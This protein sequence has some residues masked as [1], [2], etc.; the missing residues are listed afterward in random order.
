M[1]VSDRLQENYAHYYE[2]SDSQWRW[3]TSQDKAANVMSLCRDIP[4]STICDI[5]AGE[6]SLLQRLGDAAFGDKHFALEIS[7]TGIEAIRQRSIGTLVECR[8]FDG[9]T[10]PYPD[11]FFDL[12]ILS[13]VVEHVEHPRRLLNEAGRIANYILVEVPLED[14]IRLPADYRFDAVGHINYYSPKTVRHLVQTCGFE[15]VKQIITNRSHS[16]YTFRSGARGYIPYVAKETLLRLAP[17]FATLLF[18]YHSA[19]L[20]RLNR[21][22]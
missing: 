14:T 11:R 22:G 4:H 20:C 3:L 7:Q 2:N 5:G 18:T 21:A 17:K 6:G 16:S 8:L 19:M 15:V 1:N 10:I 9:Y 13:H 12:A